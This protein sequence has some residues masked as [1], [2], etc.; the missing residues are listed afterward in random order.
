[1]GVFTLQAAH[2]R[3]KVSDIS[4]ILRIVLMMIANGYSLRI[5]VAVSHASG[6]LS[7]SAV[8]LH[9][10]MR[11]LGD[12]LAWLLAEVSQC[13]SLF[14][15]ARWGGYDVIATDA[16]TVERPGAKGTTG[17]V[18]IALR[19]CTLRCIEYKITTEKGGEHFGGFE[20]MK[21]G[22]LWIGDRAYA[23]P[24]QRCALTCLLGFDK[25]RK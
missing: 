6:W 1:M 10:W 20:S 3:T 14:K 9:K 21:S 23:N 5:A 11:K 12:Y 18:H 8:A 25:R 24:P 19:L 2:L 22:Q 4:V 15:P 7:I 13:E 16:T 17:R